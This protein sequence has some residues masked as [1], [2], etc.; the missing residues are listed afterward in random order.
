VFE[1]V[2]RADEVETRGREAGVGE[3]AGPDLEA[4]PAR[5]FG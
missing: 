1:D 5:S 3:R 2:P 4:T